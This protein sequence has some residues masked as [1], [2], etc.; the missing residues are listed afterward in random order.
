MKLPARRPFFYTLF[1]A[2][3][4]ILVV[5][6]LGLRQEWSLFKESLITLTILSVAFGSFLTVSLFQG[7]WV[8]DNFG[9]LQEHI[10]RMP[11]PDQITELSTG[12][13]DLDFDAGEGCGAIILGILAWLLVA[14]IAVVLLWFFAAVA[15][16]VFMVLSAML[17]WIFFRALRFALRHGREC[18]GRLAPSL[19]YAFTYTIVYT[20]WLYAIILTT[21]Y[22]L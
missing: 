13:L 8:H 1:I 9:N 16:V 17:Y 18:R 20:S 4:T 19:R 7:V 6:F 5:W 15:W 3:A 21:H 2:T 11:F 22:L 12:D 10:R 14:A